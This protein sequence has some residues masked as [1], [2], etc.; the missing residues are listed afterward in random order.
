MMGKANVLL[1]LGLGF[2]ARRIVELLD[3]VEWHVIGTA[4][5]SAGLARLS[6]LGI[7]GLAFD[8]SAAASELA[9]AL[10]RATHLLVSA[11]PGADGD[12]LLRCHRA[13]I[14]AAPSLSWIGYLSTIGVY[15]DRHGGWV[16]ETDAAAPT[17]TRS[18]QRAEAERAWLAL[19]A[20]TAARVVLFRLAGIYGPGRSA[21]DSVLDGRARRIVKPGQ[22][23]NRIHVDDIAQ[24]VLASMAGHGTA[25]ILN[26]TD[27]EPAPPQ[28]VI[29]HA[30]RLLGCPLPPEVPYDS[31]DLSPMAR[32]FYAES[33]RVRNDLLKRDLGLT[34]RHPTYREGLAAIAA[35][36]SRGT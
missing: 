28:D 30:A 4:T 21:I 24:A 33:K 18:R 5:S 10:K 20:E 6:S 17:S 22:M 36:A 26:V 23:F 16:D 8:G 9:A 35:A 12:P 14:V 34:L 31:A 3:P 11:P 29:A 32:S 2:S 27:D 13:D 1:C 25:D 19:R 7:E 15:G